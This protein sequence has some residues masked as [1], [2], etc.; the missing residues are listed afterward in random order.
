MKD[1]T[2][3]ILNCM[4]LNEEQPSGII[5]ERINQKYFNGE[6]PKKKVKL[7]RTY[8]YYL[9]EEGC[10]QK[11]VIGGNLYYKK[12]SNER[13]LL[14]KPKREPHEIPPRIPRIPKEVVVHKE[15]SYTLSQI[16]DWFGRTPLGKMQNIFKQEFGTSD[17]FN[18][19][20]EQIKQVFQKYSYQI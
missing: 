17:V 19:S 16:M 11:S 6:I 1:L 12:I 8:L 2:L 5:V 3:A 20:Q 18:A 9:C 15:K 10:M 14:R 7:T 4:E 13:I